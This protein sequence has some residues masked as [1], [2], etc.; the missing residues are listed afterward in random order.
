MKDKTIIQLRLEEVGVNIDTIWDLV[1][2]K[3]PYY[4]STIPV[5]IELL[6][7]NIDK[8]D[9]EG[10]VRSL[11]IKEAKGLANKVLLS[12]YKKIALSNERNME[13]LKWAIGNAFETII[14]AEDVENIIPIVLDPK[15]GTSRQMF[16]CALGKLKT[17]KEKIEDVLITLLDDKDVFVHAIIALGRLRSQKAKTKIEL[18]LSHSNSFARREAK[19]ALKRIGFIQC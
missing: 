17:K 10:V 3:T 11:S 15:N 13:A 8:K 1:S 9:K 14:V 4:R 12:E 6:K 18:F 7:E 5:L 2:N 19:K 16:V